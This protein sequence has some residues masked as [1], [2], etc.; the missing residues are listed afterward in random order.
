MHEKK[1]PA[2]PTIA[3]TLGF[4]SVPLTGRTALVALCGFFVSGGDEMSIPAMLSGVGSVIS[5]LTGLGGLLSASAAQKEAE[6]QE[7]Q[8]ITSLNT[9]NSTA[10]NNLN[11]Q[12]SYNLASATGQGGDMI[13]QLGSRMGDSLASAGVYNSGAAG[14]A[15]DRAE[16]TEQ[17]SLAGLAANNT[18]S[19]DQMAAQN[20]QAGA[21]MEYNFAASQLGQAN[22]NYSQSAGGLSSFLGSLAQQNLASS[23]ANAN[24]A[25][26]PQ[27]NGNQNQG[28]TTGS[29][30]NPFMPAAAS[31]PAL[32]PSGDSSGDPSTN[33]I[34]DQGQPDTQASMDNFNQ[35]IGR[36]AAPSTPAAPAAAPDNPATP[37]NWLQFNVDPSWIPH[38]Q[39]A[40]AGAGAK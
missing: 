2:L 30:P 33:A 19:A 32:N 5:G 24:A 13:Q 28:D 26:L 10:L 7:Q 38:L 14:G 8:A 16:A 18:F 35:S 20:E 29:D 9:A 27:I 21:N 23:G 34:A 31:T 6:A 37:G 4:L 25:S 11:T 17:N 12:N 22:K 40:V 3:L 15:L 36:S 1:S 39:R